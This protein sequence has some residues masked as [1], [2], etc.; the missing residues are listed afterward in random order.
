MIFNN[1][2]ANGDAIAGT[3]F[4]GIGGS[5]G[6]SMIA[7][8]TI[9]GGAGAALTGGNFWQGA[10]IGGMVAGLNHGLHKIAKNIA[11]K[12][13]LLSRFNKIDP[14]KAAPKNVNSLIELLNDVYGLKLFYEASGEYELKYGGK[15]DE[16]RGYT[17]DETKTHIFYDGAYDSYYKL[18]STMFHEFY[19]AFQYNYNN[20]MIYSVL[21]N[22]GYKTGYMYV[23]GIE[24]PNKGECVLEWH[25]YNFEYSFLG[26]KSSYVRKGLELYKYK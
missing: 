20:G 6:V 3:G 1:L 11:I 13:D 12:K 15:S 26:N 9:S 18:A 24:I 10:V 17:F 4:S 7:F 16:Y 25:A 8:G 14:H 22:A 23:G 2:D 19:H 21:A 5:S